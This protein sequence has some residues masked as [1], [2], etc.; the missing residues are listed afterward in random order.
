MRLPLLITTVCYLSGCAN[1]STERTGL[2]DPSQHTTAPVSSSDSGSNAGTPANASSSGLVSWVGEMHQ[3][4]MEG[5]VAAQIHIAPLLIRP[6]L[7]AVGPVEGLAG[8]ITVIDGT[9]NIGVSNGQE[10]RSSRP[11]DAGAPF[12]VWA[13]VSAW[14]RQALPPEITTLDALEERL[15]A[16][17]RNAG[18]DAASPIPF[19]VEGT[20]RTLKYHVLQPV[21]GLPP[22]RESHDRAQV[23]AELT[24]TLVNLV[25]FYSTSHRGI[26]TPGS[27]DVHVHF[28]TADGSRSGHVESFDLQPGAM[29]L[30]PASSSR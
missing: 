21:S 25:G 15:P 27:S 17:L 5:K 6:G 19:R 12:L 18:F 7:N 10:T 9:V 11:L 26:F 20:A 1:S 2:T 4:I 23:H 8:E 3:T 29:L 24:A 13:N 22:G 16:L 30:L 14:K 28:V